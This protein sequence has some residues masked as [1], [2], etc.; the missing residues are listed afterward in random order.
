MEHDDP[1]EVL[2]NA[3]RKLLIQIGAVLR[4]TGR[5]AAWP[6]R[7]GPGR[8]H[9]HHAG[10]ESSRSHGATGPDTVSAFDHVP[11][12]AQNC[13]AGPSCPLAS[14]AKQIQSAKAW[15][16]NDAGVPPPPL[17]QLSW[18]HSKS[19]SRSRRTAQASHER[20][21]HRQHHET[22]LHLRVFCSHIKGGANVP[23]CSS[24][25]R[26]NRTASSQPHEEQVQRREVCRSHPPGP[27]GTQF[28]ELAFKGER[29]LDPTGQGIDVYEGETGKK[30]KPEPPPGSHAQLTQM[31]MD[32]VA[33]QG[34]SSVGG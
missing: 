28:I 1:F 7:V 26:Q 18:R 20:G 30:F 25:D 29:G 15:M 9:S 10:S 33:A 4:P 2:F 27:R 21:G 11:L 17:S 12:P 22:L 34:G 14:P 3:G 5:G 6:A 31:A 16:K 13:W 19:V 23:P 8:A 24:S 32:W